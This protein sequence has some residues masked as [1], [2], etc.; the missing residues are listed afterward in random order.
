M[1][2]YHISNY[3]DWD[4]GGCRS[5]NKM[6]KFVNIPNGKVSFYVQISLQDE[7]NELI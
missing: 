7:K 3:R 1:S 5:R 2:C 4:G 6:V